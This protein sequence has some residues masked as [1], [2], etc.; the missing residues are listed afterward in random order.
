ML[1]TSASLYGIDIDDDEE[2]V[3]GGEP[4]ILDALKSDYIDIQGGTTGEGIHTGVM[5]GTILLALNSFAGLDIRSE[6]VSLI[7]HLPKRWRRMR[8]NFNLGKIVI[9]K[10]KQNCVFLVISY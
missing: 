2:L 8:F 4:Y 3:L 1:I 6:N 5:A 7:P 10:F 9:L